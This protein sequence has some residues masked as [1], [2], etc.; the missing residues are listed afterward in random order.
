MTPSPAFRGR[1]PL[2]PP[3]PPAERSVTTVPSH[4][5]LLCW[6]PFSR[7]LKGPLADHSQCAAQHEGR[8]RLRANAFRGISL[9]E[10]L[11]AARSLGS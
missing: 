6:C 2:V 10:P 8:Q 9:D 11:L 4:R 7:T 3:R 5:R 1:I